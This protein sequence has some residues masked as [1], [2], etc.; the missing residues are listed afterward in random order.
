M[1]LMFYPAQ[2]LLIDAKVV[3]YFVVHHFRYF[4]LGLR[5]RAALGLYRL[6]EDTYFIRRDH[7]V[8]AAT[9][10]LGHTLVKAQQLVGVS[11]F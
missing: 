11:D 10:D 5:I 3:G 9:P 2:S 8:S 6:L 4:G 7:P 1:P